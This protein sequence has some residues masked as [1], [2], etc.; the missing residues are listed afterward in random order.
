MLK[1]IYWNFFKRNIFGITA[2]MRVLPDFIIIG[3]MKC[4][5]TS[6]YY[7]ICE[8]PCTLAAAYDEIG[9]FD[10]NF[11]LGINWYRSMFPTQKIMNKIREDTG[12]SI[13]GEDTPFYF[14]KKEVAERI[15]LDI[16]KTKIIVILRNPV[17]RAYSNYNLAVRENNEKLTFEE[18]IEE[19]IRFLE[20]HTFRDAVD[21]RRSYLSKG[22][23]KNQI[24]LWF[25]V[26]PRKQIH[27]LSTEDMQQKPKQELLKI[28]RFLGIPEY[29]IKNQQKQKVAKYEEM[30]VE[31]R[32]KLLDFYKPYN[33]DFFQIIQQRFNWEN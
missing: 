9:F 21:S 5:T 26:F 1:K 32:K 28:F 23:Y 16:P 15:S 14:W 30:D 8:H 17:D 27:V 19:E 20:N 31:T 25:D 6:L 10:S 29:T 33:E 13:T 22:M 7:D 3:S 18:T 4:G 2:S 11:H 12:Y 24:K